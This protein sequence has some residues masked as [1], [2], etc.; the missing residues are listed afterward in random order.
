[1]DAFSKP[2]ALV[3]YS[4]FYQWT[5]LKLWTRLREY[6]NQEQYRYAPYFHAASYKLPSFALYYNNMVC[7]W[8]TKASST[9]LRQTFLNISTPPTLFCTNAKCSFINAIKF[10]VCT[11]SFCKNTR[12][13]R[14]CADGAYDPPKSASSPVI[15]SSRQYIN[16]LCQLGEMGWILS[17][18]IVF[19]FGKDVEP[20]VYDWSEV[21]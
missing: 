11:G 19:D 13:R 7:I 17:A 18:V 8:S 2:L 3:T 15:S 12:F 6:I 9:L 1:M 21:W 14:S 20:Y 10:V 5:H 4:T 16:A